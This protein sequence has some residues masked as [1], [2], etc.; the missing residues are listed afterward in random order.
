[1]TGL[2]EVT[3]ADVIVV[4]DTEL[5]A[6]EGSL[7]R[8]WSGANEYPEIV[9]IGAVKLERQSRFSEMDAFEQ[10]VR[11]RF[12]PVLSDY[13][14]C[15]TGIT[16]QEVNEKGIDLCEALQRFSDFVLP[17][18]MICSNGGDHEILLLNCDLYGIPFPF[19]ISRFRDVGPLLSD[20][21]RLT[22]HIESGRLDKVFNFQCD[23]PVHNGLADARRL[24]ETMR[25]LQKNG[26]I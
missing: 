24:A 25:H 8:N 7:E 19:E 14:T 21:A 6:W 15:L 5:T 10:L 26:R 18:T 20:E 22:T 13:F 11:P 17:D 23:L 1:M 2:K 9:Q 16:Q 3:R 12:N 4:F